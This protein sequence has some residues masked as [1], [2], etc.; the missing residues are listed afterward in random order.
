MSRLWV[1]FRAFFARSSFSPSPYFSA[2][3]RIA[4]VTA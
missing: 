1:R 3:S 4:K 2:C